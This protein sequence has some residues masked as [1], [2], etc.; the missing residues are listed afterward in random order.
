MPK[1][2]INAVL[3][4]RS[5]SCPKPMIKVM[6][7]LKSMEKESILQVVCDDSTTKKTIP[8]LCKRGGYKLLSKSER[9]GVIKFIIQ[10]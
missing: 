9:K 8:S 2:K 1:I 4:M 5:L 10:R 6:N 7:T 3:D